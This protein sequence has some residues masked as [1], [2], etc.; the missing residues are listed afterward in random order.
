MLKLALDSFG[1]V[2]MPVVGSGTNMAKAVGGYWIKQG[3]RGKV[4]PMSPTRGRHGNFSGYTAY[5]AS[6]GATDGL[7]RVLATERAKYGI[8]VD[9]I[10]PT[11]FRSKLTQWMW[12][13]DE[14]GKASRARTLCRI[15]LGGLGEPEDIL[16]MALCL[17][18]PASDFR[19]GRVIDVDGG[20]TAG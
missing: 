13:D 1:K 17:L 2:D 8:A 10:A 18:S 5:C 14:V 7:T 4:A 16:G 12:R 15:P 20:F 9:A 3:V 19:A 11:A 6:K